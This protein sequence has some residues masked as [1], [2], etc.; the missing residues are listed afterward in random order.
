M[1]SK[2]NT[3]KPV[4]PKPKSAPKKDNE[5]SSSETGKG[6]EVDGAPGDA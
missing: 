6:E 1:A 5:D 3:T 2:K 4:A